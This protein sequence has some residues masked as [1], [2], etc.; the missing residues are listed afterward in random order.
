MKTLV[1]A[2]ATTRGSGYDVHRG[3]TAPSALSGPGGIHPVDFAVE[4][5]CTF[6][7][8]LYPTAP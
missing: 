6:W 2:R 5:H 1:A 7:K 4:H 8:S 3:V